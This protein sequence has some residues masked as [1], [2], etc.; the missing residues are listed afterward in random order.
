[1][2]L[3]CAS[4]IHEGSVERALRARRKERQKAEISGGTRLATASKL[5]RRR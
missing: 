5:Y 2:V 1:M 4:E 3:Q